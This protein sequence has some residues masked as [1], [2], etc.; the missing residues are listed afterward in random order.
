M[1][2]KIILTGGGTAG[3]VTPNIALIPELEKENFDIYYI[4]TKAGIERKLI[5]D[6]GIKYFPITAG[7]LRRYFDLENLTDIGRIL[8]GFGQSLKVIRKIKPDII[9]SKGGFVSTPVVWAARLCKVPVVIHESDITPGLAN[10]LSIPFADKV[11]YAFPETGKFIQEKKACLT[12]IPIRKELFNGNANLG[13]K[14]CGFTAGKPI[15]LVM[16]GS[17]GSKFINDTV[18]EGLKE[19]ITTFQVCHICGKGAIDET[20][21]G[22]KGYKQFEY[23]TEEQPHLFAM[24]DVVVSRAG[25]TTLFE[26][27]ALKKP[28]LLIPL[29]RR[30]S[31][32]DQ[33]LNARSFEEQ[34]FSYVLQEEDMNPVS[35]LENTLKIY[36]DRRTIINKMKTSDLGNSSARVISVIMDL[37][38]S[39]QT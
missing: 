10:K 3:H 36:K 16:G 39:F 15:L 9:F 5:V 32:G 19:L 28:N 1:V 6:M 23:V 22:L 26:L 25:A 38:N 12:G 17:Q 29:S 13:M 11:C 30:A 24:S 21:V 14:M 27:L 2:A 34:G 18:R 8:K 37:M 4:G 35:L 33:I 20:L 31:R 7:K